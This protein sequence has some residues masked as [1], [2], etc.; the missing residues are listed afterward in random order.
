M[1]VVTIHVEV[2]PLTV[3]VANDP[4]SRARGLKKRKMLT[5]SSGMLFVFPQP[6]ILRFWMK[7]TPH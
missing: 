2:V 6:Q 4:V 7:D 3:E 5:P 1:E